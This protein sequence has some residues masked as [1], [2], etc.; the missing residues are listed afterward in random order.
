M[1]SLFQRLILRAGI[2]AT[3]LLLSLPLLATN[4]HATPFTD[5]P[6]L[7]PPQSPELFYNELQV[8]YLT[9][10]KRR[11]Q[12]LAPLR[13]NRELSESARWFA[14]NS[15]EE[16][17][18]AY[19]GHADTENRS[20]GD[21]LIL[22]NYT[23]PNTWGENVVCGFTSP[24]AAVN[25]WMNSEGHKKNILQTIYREIGIGY[26]RNSQTGRGYIVQ[27]FSY[28]P[29]YAPV[30]I[31]NEA[32]NTT[33]AEVQL[34]IYNPAAQSG[35]EGMGDAVEMMIANE[36]SFA[37]AQWEPFAQEKSWTL[38]A[39]EGWR[40]VYVKTRDAQGRTTIVCDTIY[41]GATLPT[42]T[43]ALKQA[44]TV[45]R[46]LAF[47][48]LD[49]SGWPQVQLSVNWQGDD[50][51]VLF[52]HVSGEGQE[53]SDAQAIGGTV[54]QLSGATPS[55][56][57][58]WTTEFHKN[59]PL[60]A[61]FRVKVSDNQSGDE[62]LSIKISGGG[63]EYGPLVIHGTDF[64]Q[65]DVYQEFSL[66]FTFHESADPYLIFN[67]HGTGKS[68]IAVDTITVYTA[69]MPSQNRLEWTVL[70]GYYRSRGIWGR[71]VNE[72]GVFTE[73]TELIPNA[74]SVSPTPPPVAS[75]PAPAPP[76]PQPLQ[77]QV[78]LPIVRK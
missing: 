11:E 17:E 18:G 8:V 56:A 34:Y 77:N 33:A 78:L 20:P 39:G 10:L 38:E 19:C 46:E 36:P 6:V 3:G 45:E 47:F 30:I 16:R 70:G 68:T 22:F 66:P 43:L 76:A 55:H 75:T 72:A 21:R 51:D 42:E 65:A 23:N 74:E 24:E 15:V 9:N 59:V 73:A 52:E 58:Y 60:T 25:G 14:Y 71:F 64:T 53:I 37:N 29:E 61:Y 63:T 12:G 5:T 28:D 67:L 1:D 50:S 32:P 31:N 40:A 26:Y 44:S 57:R 48:N 35:L 27:D 7:A 49:K 69:A 62:V 13:W 2:L 54:L 41:L 4:A